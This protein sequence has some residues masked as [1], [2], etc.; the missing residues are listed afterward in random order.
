MTTPALTFDEQ[1]EWELATFGSLELPPP[2]RRVVTR[3]GTLPGPPVQPERTG[4]ALVRRGYEPLRA[5]LA[6]LLL[7]EA[8]AAAVFDKGVSI[9]LGGRLIETALRLTLTNPID[10]FA[11]PER[12]DLLNAMEADIKAAGKVAANQ[13]D[14]HKKWTNEATT[15]FGKWKLDKNKH[16]MTLGVC[17]NVVSMLNRFWGHFRPPAPAT[18]TTPSFQGTQKLFREVLGNEHFTA[19][20]LDAFRAGIHT[21]SLDAI[22]DTRNKFAH[23]DKSSKTATQHATDAQYENFANNAVGNDSFAAWYQHGP[24]DAVL[25]PECGFLHRLLTHLKPVATDRIS[26]RGVCDEIAYYAPPQCSYSVTVQIEGDGVVVGGPE[27]GGPTTRGVSLSR[28]TP[29]RPQPFSHGQAIRYTLKLTQP[30]HVRVF[31]CDPEGSITQLWPNQ[32]DIA[33]GLVPHDTLYPLLG[34]NV[35]YLNAKPGEKFLVAVATTRANDFGPEFS[36]RMG[37]THVTPA[38]VLAL[39]LESAKPRAVHVLRYHVG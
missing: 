11:G 35:L 29:T 18:P 6:R 3:S 13:N 26:S 15:L 27:L 21:P 19:A 34:G 9:F 36:P 25:P 37:F 12:G 4:R 32:W 24:K 2:K 23:A 1:I 7:E 20:G 39:L 8:S 10:D 38:H 33:D 14:A 17:F 22:L 16:T 31:D 28:P 30:A 5:A